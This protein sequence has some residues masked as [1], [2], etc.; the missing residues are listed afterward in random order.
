MITRLAVAFVTLLLLAGCSATG[1]EQ[2]APSP[3]PT[4][5][6]TGG[7]R[8][9]PEIGT[10]SAALAPVRAAVP[11]TR[12]VIDSLGVDIPVEPVGIEPDGLMQLPPDVAIAGWYQYGSDPGSPTGTT[13]IS[14]HVDSLQYGLGPFSQLKNVA[15]GATVTVTSAD[16]SVQQYVVESVQSILKSQLPLDQVFDRD[17]A[18]RLALITCGGQFDYDALNYSDNVVV[19]ATPVAS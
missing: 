14:A 7:T 10:Q 15:A 5:T 8:E 1:V 13:V 4:P 17:G 9:G 6:A 3:V 18:P 2:L 12:V 11:P 16:G 19:I